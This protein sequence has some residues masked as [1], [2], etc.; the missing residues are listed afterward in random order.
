MYTAAANMV[1]PTNIAISSDL[2]SVAS[3]WIP[4]F[5]FAFRGLTK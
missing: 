3:Q 5:N 2:S 1:P 4:Y